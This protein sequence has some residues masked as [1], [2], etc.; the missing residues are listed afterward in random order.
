MLGTAAYMSP[1]QA[2]GKSVD[3]R[4]DIWAFGVV[5]YEMLT[6]ARLFA[7]ASIPDTLGQIFSRE[8]DLAALPAAT[9]SRIR[10]LIAR[11]L[12]KDPRQRLRDIGD[13]RLELDGVGDIDGRSPAA[14]TRTLWRA[15]PWALA[16]ATAALAG[17]TLWVRSGADTTARDAMY[18]DIGFPP[19]VEPLTIST[20]GLAI[21][22]D[23]RVVAMIGVKDSVRRLFVHRIDR[24]DTIEVPGTKRRPERRFLARRRERGIRC[25]QRVPDAP[26]PDGPA[27]KGCDPWR[28]PHRRARV[29]PRRHRLRPR[30]G[31]LGRLGGGWPTP[32]AHRARCRA[33]RSRPQP[34]DG[35]AGRAPRALCQPDFRAWRR[36]DRIGADR[37]RPTVR[38]R[39]TG[40]DPRVVAHRPSVVCER[41]RGASGSLR[42]R[43]RDRT[44]S[45]RP[46]H[47][48]RR[49]GSGPVRRPGI[50]GVV[51]RNVGVPAGRVH[52]QAP[53]V[54]G[55][56]RRDQ[57][58]RSATGR[59]CKP[60]DRA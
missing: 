23:A 1:E 32:A 45:R 36:A 5:L 28:G 52:R 4:A 41:W 20:G 26:L 46:C 13:A 6:G 43:Q 17:W 33:A 35:A 14:P 19:D 42:P 2:R 31:P 38:R 29:E 40:D 24:A 54:G 48:F 15:L 59:L 30:R 25:R 51:H 12:V 55:S 9:P 53:G 34:P 11:C 44:R 8:P 60:A 7:G 18:F 3:K 47:A 22:P 37:R 58:P 57:G 21:S 49:R 10:A 39:R 16:L 27:T 50:V 56:R